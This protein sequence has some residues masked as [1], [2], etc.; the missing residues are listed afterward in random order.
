M[1]VL[2]REKRGADELRPGFV[3]LG[4]ILSVKEKTVPAKEGENSTW[5]RC[6]EIMRGET[7]ARFSR[8][9]GR[10][11]TGFSWWVKKRELGRHRTAQRI[12]KKVRPLGA[13]RHNSAQIGG[14]FGPAR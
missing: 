10:E 2:E 1:G 14:E 8:S 9:N 11:G 4:R 13:Q 12:K 3:K 6:Q 7:K 5:P